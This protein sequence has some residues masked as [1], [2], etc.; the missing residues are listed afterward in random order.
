MKYT[1]EIIVFMRETVKTVKQVPD[2]AR[3]VNA[4]FNV[5]FTCKQVRS[6]LCLHGLRLGYGGMPIG[7]EI[8]NKRGDALVKVCNKGIQTKRYRRKHHL[9]WE[10]E[11]GAIPKSHR[12]I[13]L[14]GN[15]SNFES[16][17][18]Y[19]LHNRV[20]GYMS[21]HGLKL[22]GDKERSKA[23]IKIA[24]LAIKIKERRKDLPETPLKS[25]FSGRAVGY[26]K[27]DFP[28]DTFFIDKLGNRIYAGKTPDGWHVMKDGKKGVKP[29]HTKFANMVKYRESAEQA[30]NDLLCYASRVGYCRPQW[31]SV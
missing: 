29:L 22:C 24:E 8:K 6:A 3:L 19:C 15:K 16:D 12:I 28:I 4:K 13:F 11:N 14:D 7:T 17:N 30:I 1:P 21:L 25:P 27:F 23:I 26:K 10:A 20:R 31:G 5:N 18:L 2:I 9:I